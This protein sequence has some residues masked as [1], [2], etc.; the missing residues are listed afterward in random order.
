M[1]FTCCAVTTGDVTK[2]IT[3]TKCNK[4]NHLKCI[5]PNE[6]IK[7]LS[8]DFKNKWVCP[9]CT[10]KQPKSTKSDNTPVRAASSNSAQ[11][12]ALHHENI[13]MR[14]GGS[15]SGCD[16]ESVCAQSDPTL[17]ENIKEYFN[18][19]FA[20]LRADLESSIVKRLSAE[21][22]TVKDEISSIKSSM[23]FLHGKY[24]EVNKRL[25][26][27]DK[28]IKTFS[29]KTL[30]VGELRL[31]MDNMLKDNNSKEQWARRSNIEIVGVPQRKNEDL[32]SVLRD[33]ARVADFKLDPSVDV[34]FVTRVAPRN[35][36]DK[37]IKPIV[38]RFLA[39][40]KK[41]EFLS[42]AKKLKLKCSDLGFSNNSNSI[43]LN[44]HLTSANKALLQSTKKLAKE[45]GYS[46]VWVKN[47]TIMARRSDTS[48]V[49]H[50][51]QQ[52]DLKK[53]V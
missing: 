2:R 1:V 28:E 40:W 8:Q 37:K 32:I 16:D 48:P 23:E 19:E 39:R 29:A 30:E 12:A 14:R 33:I 4:H 6:K 51:L 36:D 26:R 46:Y 53:I 17:L 11:S 45:R 7:E 34:D 5:F 49:V 18:L 52:S 43:Y 44:D 38:V 10:A 20:R 13:N 22:Q 24:E 47:C 41:D 27:V 25:D 42:H 3:C 50:I 31:S 15:A 9:A 35:N 21:I